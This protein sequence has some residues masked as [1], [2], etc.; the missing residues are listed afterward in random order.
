[1]FLAIAM[2][3]VQKYG[4]ASAIQTTNVAKHIAS[5]EY[6][7]IGVV[8]SG[9]RSKVDG[10]FLYMLEEID[11]E[12]R[13]VSICTIE[14]IAPGDQL[15]V[16]VSSS[17]QGSECSDHAIYYSGYLSG[18]VM[19]PIARSAISSHQAIMLTES[20]FSTLGCGGGIADSRPGLHRRGELEWPP[21]FYARRTRSVPLSEVL[22][23]I[24]TYDRAVRRV[25]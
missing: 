9:S 22:D 13:E 2:L 11:G 4:I 12:R 18:V 15:L 16:A 17:A 6:W 8:V 20:E 25:E 5:S 3:L 7:F 1:M 24:Q 21:D 19:L 14:Q 10:H 23:C